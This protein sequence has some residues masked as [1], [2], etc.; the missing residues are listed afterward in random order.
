MNIFSFS[1]PSRLLMLYGFFASVCHATAILF[2]AT[3]MTN[4]TST[5]LFHK[6][7]PMLECS[8]A[9]FIIILIG[10]LVFEY[11]DKAER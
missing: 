10:V 9:S 11:I 6:Y 3:A 4:A 1:R 7:F 8:M 5:V 2:M